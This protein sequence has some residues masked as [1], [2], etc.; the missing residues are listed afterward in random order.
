M[1]PTIV[2]TEKRLQNLDILLK[3]RVQRLRQLLLSK[4]DVTACQQ[5]NTLYKYMTF[6][7]NLTIILLAVYT[8]IVMLVWAVSVYHKQ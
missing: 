5:Q 4:Y 7:R 8:I 6:K 2:F 1:L 3:H